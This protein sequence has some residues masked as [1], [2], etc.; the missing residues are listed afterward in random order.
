MD[1]SSG[2]DSISI[3]WFKRDL[4]LYDHEPLFLVGTKSYP[5]LL[6]YCFEPSVMTYPDSDTRHWRFVY[7][8]LMDI[9]R[10]L[11][12][13]D[14]QVY[15]CHDEVLDIL[16]KLSEIYD[17]KHIFSHQETGNKRT[18]D[19]D[20]AIRKFCLINDIDWQ[21]S[22]SN[23]IVRRLKNRKNWE[24]RWKNTMI[25]PIIK[26]DFGSYI[27]LKPNPTVLVHIQRNNIPA[28]LTIPDTNFQQGGET[29]AWKYMRSFLHDR[30]QRYS[31]HISKPELSRSSCSR[32]SPYIAYGNISLRTVYQCALE[33]MTNG[34]H[35]QALTNF[36]SRLHWHCHFIQKFEDECTMEFLPVNKAYNAMVKPRNESYIVAW[37]NGKTGVPLIDASMRCLIT[38]GY[39]NFRMRAMLVSFFVFNLW[40][41]WREL[42]YLARQFLDYEPGI[43]YP[44]I[45]MQAG[46][47]GV[48]TIRIYN[49]IKNAIDHD[50]NGAFIR[51]WV[52]ELTN[53]PVPFIY[54]PW[55]LSIM[56]QQLYGVIIGRD[57]P[58]P[59][60]DVEE[61]RKKAADI[62]WSFRKSEDVKEEGLRI[63]AKHTNQKGRFTVHKQD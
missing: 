3:V 34:S 51:K 39:V 58:S 22:L 35:Q 11:T 5:V 60:V 6:L 19:R 54:E 32:L 44:Q 56:E 63:I 18:F 53:V 12:A 49:P 46:I 52:P 16:C 33:R 2:K 29:L 10:R 1:A 27:F 13:Y 42:H 62:V 25:K 23:G 4:R 38:T 36:I 21:E 17:I 37:K 47:T 61:S 57:Y 55:K 30:Y 45:H 9:N 15:I 8:S 20:L 40:Q 43:H 50:E 7:E 48:N 41:D 59:I 14:T 24:K 31:K 26:I 28:I